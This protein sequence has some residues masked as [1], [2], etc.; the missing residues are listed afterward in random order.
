MLSRLKLVLMIF[1]SL[2]ISVGFSQEAETEDE[3]VLNDDVTMFEFSIDRLFLL[4]NFKNNVGKNLIG[5]SCSI[6]NQREAEGYSFFGVNV[7]FSHIGSE[8]GDVLIGG[9]SSFNDNTSSN[10]TS[11]LFVY[12]H[13]LPFYYKILEP[14]FEVGV[15][16]QYFFTTTTT[17]YFDTESASEIN[18][19]ESDFGLA[20]GMNL[21]LT[22][23]IVNRLF[24]LVKV[25]YYGGTATSYLTPDDTDLANYPVDRFDQRTSQTNFLKIQF[26]AAYSF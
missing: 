15:G 2:V 14:Y 18:F 9:I 7:N 5:L 23:K 4:D 25:G 19:E 13:Y 20:Y 3:E 16:P 17:T 6:L 24:A 11:V 10:F 8:S 21:G 22:I 26:G 12:R 1:L